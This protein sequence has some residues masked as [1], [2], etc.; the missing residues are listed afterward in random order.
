MNFIIYG[1]S[2]QTINTTTEIQFLSTQTLAF[3]TGSRTT[4]GTLATITPATGKTFVLLGASVSPSTSP[5]L[6]ACRYLCELRNESNV[7]DFLGGTSSSIAAGGGG[8][9]ISQSHSFVRGD[10]LIGDGI[11]TYTLEVTVI[12]AATV[13]GAIYGYL[14]D[15]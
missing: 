3:A 12:I 7:R 9:A 13:N 8:S 11:K 4:T 5:I 2:P 10:T 6:G 14:I 15:T 1:K